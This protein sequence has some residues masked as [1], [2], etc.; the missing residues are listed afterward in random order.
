MVIEERRTN[1]T[2]MV[3]GKHAPLKHLVVA[4]IV[5]MPLAFVPMMLLE[6]KTN[7][8]P[9]LKAEELQEVLN[10]FQPEAKKAILN[11]INVRNDRLVLLPYERLDD[12]V[13]LLKDQPAVI[14]QAPASK[15][16]DILEKLLEQL[17]RREPIPVQLQG[18]GIEE[19]IGA[20]LPLD[21]IFT[22]ES[23]KKLPL[24]SYFQSGKPIILTLNYSDCPQLC[25]IQLNN[26]VEVMADNK[27]NPGRDFEIVTVS[28]NP[29]EGPA[30][31]RVA[32]RNY[33]K[34]L[35][36]P[37]DSWHFLTTENNDAIK[38]LADTV[39]YRYKYDP[40]KHDY[41]HSS[42]L[43]F[44]SPTGVVSLYY[45]GIKYD[46]KEL[47]KRIDDARNGVQYASTSEEDNLL[48]CKVID[49]TKPYAAL[50]MQIMKVVAT[51]MAIG[52]V[53]T[54]TILWMI[55]NRQPAVLPPLQGEKP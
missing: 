54:L 37:Q 44:C 29:N 1:D 51:I 8:D 10:A 48:N 23:G 9:F 42:T 53:I 38:K 50:S 39:G 41:A 22:D 11:H 47:M 15:R 14:A 52:L 7:Q 27:I 12:M 17:D 16:D 4:L 24:G 6:S 2:P 43:I 40:V 31:A 3:T 55:P 36:A 34:D 45:Q 35:N 21:L 26:F 13:K 30:K 28:I 5:L 20:R 25:H 46:P 33:L 19:K 18:V 49:N 32:K